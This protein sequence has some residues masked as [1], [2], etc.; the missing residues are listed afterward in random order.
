VGGGEFDER[1]L[2]S[3][4]KRRVR[5][6]RVKREGSGFRAKREYGAKRLFRVQ[7]VPRIPSA[8]EIKRLPSA[9][10]PKSPSAARLKRLSSEASIPLEE[11]AA[12]PFERS[13]KTMEEGTTDPRVHHMTCERTTALQSGIRPSEIKEQCT[14]YRQVRWGHAR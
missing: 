3:G 11:E 8:A 13:E 4:A 5:E 9:A 14:N 6:A 2:R 7:R 12:D 1:E 10:R